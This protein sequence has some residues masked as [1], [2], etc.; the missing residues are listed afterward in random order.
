MKKLSLAFTLIV[1]CFAA[2]AFAQTKKPKVLKYFAPKYPPA[3]QATRT[4]GDVIVAVK[5]D[6]QGKVIE[7]KAE[8][9][10]PLLRAVCEISAQDWVFS[11]DESEDR[12]AKIT[13]AF[14]FSENASRKNNYRA[15]DVKIKF[16][17]P[18]RL[19][20]KAAFYPT[21]DY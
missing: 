17:K 21:I 8:S 19:E 13:F 14:A 18:Y 2:F 11:I 1:F 20:I 6:K 5:I 10:H 4:T 9:G 16:K 12:E 15:T 3:A 7:A